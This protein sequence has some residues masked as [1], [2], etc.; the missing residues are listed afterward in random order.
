MAII[1][2][3]GGADS[4]NGGSAADEISGLGGNDTLNGGGG[5]DTLI[6]GAGSDSLE[7]GAGNDLYIINATDVL[8]DSG[9]ID[10]VRAAF[11]YTLLSGFEELELLGNSAINGTG[12]ELAN[13]LSGNPG[14]NLL[15]GGGGND[16]LNGGG[17]N[18][19]LN[20][21][22]GNDLLWGQPGDDYLH[23]GTGSDVVSY[24]TAA[25]GVAVN[26][27]AGVASGGDGNDTLVSV[28]SAAGSVHDDTLKGTVGK[29]I[30]LGFSGND[31]LDG[32]A[33]NDDMSGGAGDDRLT[34]RGGQ[35]TFGFSDALNATTNVDR[36]TDFMAIDDTIQL[37]RAIFTGIATGNLA[38][39]RFHSAP[40]ATEAHDPGD[41]IVYNS[42]TGKLYYDADGNG[43]NSS[44]ILFATLVGAPTLTNA[45]FLIVA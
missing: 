2:G 7:G 45:D 18:D 23:G 15:K 37:D 39:G 29:N 6:G 3:T 19:T 34:G 11:S 10:T 16:T 24:A 30:L 8:R 13:V 26:L 4:L 5:N 22:T 41:R 21:G 32:G 42:D 33:G 35:D 20:G 9:G 38:L 27:A 28:E 40:G 36:I 25:L 43:A 44:A 14:N 17:G 31:T 12:N 1:T